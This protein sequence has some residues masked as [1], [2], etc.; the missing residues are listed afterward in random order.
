LGRLSKTEP[1]TGWRGFPSRE[2]TP[3]PNPPRLMVTYRS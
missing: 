2:S 1:P 3:P